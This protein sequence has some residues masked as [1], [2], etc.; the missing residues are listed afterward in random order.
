MYPFSLVKVFSTTGSEVL[1]KEIC[2]SLR[3]RLPDQLT[4]GGNLNLS[5]SDVQRFSNENMQ[6]QVENVRGHF[7][8]VI[9][10]QVP[11]VSD[12]L[13]ELFALLDAINNARPANVLL[14]F[15]YMPYS[16]SDRKN[17]PRIST[18]G[19]RLAHIFSQSFGIKRVILLDPHDSHIKHYFDPVADEISATYLLVDYLERK[20][21][22]NLDKSQSIV[23]F[24]DQGSATRYKSVAYLLR[25]PTA[26]IEKDRPDDSERPKLSRIV[27]EVRGKHCILIDDEILTGSTAVGD[28]EILKENDATSISMIAVHLILR[29]KKMREVELME[30]FNNSFIERFIVTDSI[31]QNQEILGP[32]FIVLSIAPFLGEAIK[33]SIVGQSLTELH[34]KDSVKLYR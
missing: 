19:C 24:S 8:V 27:G 20:V 16:R 14:V 15:P 12:G 9:H 32:K 18:M 11:P 13:I 5:N 3:P 29:D 7:V 4:S 1:A 10:T 28:A 6:V 30:K 2:K 22:N 25:L 34:Q 31:P 21:F 17:K 33:R 26:Y 23:V